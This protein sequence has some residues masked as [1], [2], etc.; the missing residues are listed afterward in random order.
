MYRKIVTNGRCLYRFNRFYAQCR[1][2]LVPHDGSVHS[3]R[4]LKKALTIAQPGD[5]LM[6][7]RVLVPSSRLSSWDGVGYTSNFE[8]DAFLAQQKRRLQQTVQQAKKMQN[9]SA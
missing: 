5:H 1:K 7:L 3:E 9:V 8:T 4:A 6:I 2:I